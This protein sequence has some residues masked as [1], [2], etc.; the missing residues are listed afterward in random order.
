MTVPAG[1]G[2]IIPTPKL[3]ISAWSHPD[4][5]YCWAGL[6]HAVA[7]LIG[8]DVL[9]TAWQ[10]LQLLHLSL[11]NQVDKTGTAAVVFTGLVLFWPALLPPRWARYGWISSAACIWVFAFIDACAESTCS[12]IQLYIPQLTAYSV[13]MALFFVSTRVVRRKASVI[14]LGILAGLLPYAITDVIYRISPSL[15]NPFV[16]L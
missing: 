10:L 11:L 7:V 3:D 15:L 16:V 12:A 1:V 4:P 9:G 6:E 2:P 5:L 8:K 14:A 13:T